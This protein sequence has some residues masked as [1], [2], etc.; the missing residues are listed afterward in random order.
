M[1]MSFF[2]PA[3]VL[4]CV[5]LFIPMI[6]TLIFSFTDFFALNPSLTHFTGLSNYFSI[7]KDEDFRLAFFNTWKFVLIIVPVQGL[8][9][10]GLAQHQL[11]KNREITDE[12]N[13]R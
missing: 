2:G 3:L 10:L 5:F 12:N 13:S 9:A 8:G 7:F 11:I 1:G 6:L 4:L